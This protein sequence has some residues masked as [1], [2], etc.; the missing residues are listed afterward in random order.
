MTLQDLRDEYGGPHKLGSS[1]LSEIRAAANRVCHT[2]PPLKYAG[3][4]GWNDDAI[5]DLVQDVTVGRLLGGGQLDYIMAHTADIQHFRALLDRQVRQELSARRT[6]TLIDNLVD[7]CGE[8][9]IREPFTVANASSTHRRDPSYRLASRSVEGRPPTGEE[10]R[11][12]AAVIRPLPRVGDSGSDR[13]SAVYTNETLQAALKLLAETLPC[14][15][16]IRDIDKI[17]SEVLTSWLPSFLSEEEGD[18]IASEKA[19]PEEVAILREVIDKIWAEL[20]PEEL[21]HF[22]LLMAGCSFDEIAVNLAVSRPTELKRRLGLLRVLEAGL[23][24]LSES[25]QKS[26]LAELFFGSQR[27]QKQ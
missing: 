3:V 1:I 25:L 19:G 11:I 4:L 15:F 22:R 10:L 24:D 17:F 27:K 2:Y 26:V 13:A 23:S 20:S 9:L 14:S 5:E 8:I 7:R 21:R 6:R 18:L 12:A 16:S